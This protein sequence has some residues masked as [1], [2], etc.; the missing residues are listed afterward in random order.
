MGRY[1]LPVFISAWEKTWNKYTQNDGA[2]FA[3]PHSRMDLD[4]DFMKKDW[5]EVIP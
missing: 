3:V 5:Q 2:I 4:G 1:I